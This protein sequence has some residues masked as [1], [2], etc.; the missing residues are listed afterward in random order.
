MIG[1]FVVNACL[2]HQT[3]KT[4]TATQMFNPESGFLNY[5]LRYCAA[6]LHSERGRDREGGR[7]GEGKGG[8]PKKG[9]FKKGKCNRRQG[10]T[11]CEQP[12]N[13][14]NLCPLLSPSDLQYASLDPLFFFILVTS[15]K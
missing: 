7:K 6:E 12:V 13:L 11:D 4:Q 5:S 15:I 2:P 9:S 10:A 14:S 3:Q 8:Y 1:L